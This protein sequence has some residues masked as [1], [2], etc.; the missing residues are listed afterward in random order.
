MGAF[1]PSQTVWQTPYY[2]SGSYY[3]PAAYS[4]AGGGVGV[5]DTLYLY[6]FPVFKTV[7]FDRIGANHFA[8]Q[9]PAALARLAVFR[10]DF[11]AS[12]IWTL[13]LDAGTIDLS[14]AVSRK[15]ITISQQLTPNLYWV[16][17]RFEGAAGSALARVQ[18]TVNRAYPFTPK[19]LNA[20]FTTP[21]TGFARASSTGALGNI[22]PTRAELETT[23][24]IPY[25]WMRAV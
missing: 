12:G 10:D 13:I 5:L 17:A 4:E 25:V 24:D 11:A 1:G 9:T 6:P 2:L 21:P 7:T 14:T 3:G 20:N 19:G 16:G 15:E 8:T 18:S 22:T 23:A